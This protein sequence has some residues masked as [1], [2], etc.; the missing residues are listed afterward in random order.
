MKKTLLVIFLLLVIIQ[1][2]VPAQMIWQKEAVLINGTEYKFRTEPIDPNDPFIGKY[3]VLNF[4]TQRYTVPAKQ[5]LNT[6]DEIY[7]TF[8]KDSQGFAEID[9]ITDKIPSRNDYLKTYA[10]TTETEKDSIA[11]F[12]EYPFTR[13][14]MEE[15]KAPEAEILYGSANRDAASK[16]YALVALHKG[17]AAIKNVFV[18]DTSITQMVKRNIQQFRRD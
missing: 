4:K 3:I 11:I 9:R 5:P 14:Y 12:I 15:S 13:F 1:W 18:N 17:E 16:V 2:F 6:N 8:K 10:S 7:V